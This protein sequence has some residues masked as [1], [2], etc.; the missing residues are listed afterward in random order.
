MKIGHYDSELGSK[1]GVTTYIRRIGSAQENAGHTVYYFSNRPCTEA[2]VANNA[3][4][5][6]SS[7]ED[8]Y[9]Q[10]KSLGLDILH[11][12]KGVG[13]LPP[14]DLAV[15]RTLHGHQPYCPSGSKFLKRWNQPC[16]RPYSL[17]GCLWGHLVDHCGSMRPQNLHENFQYT[18]AERNTLRGI[19]VITVSQF[20]KQQ[21]V[22]IGY[23]ADSID[24][25]YNF[26]PEQTSDSSPPNTGIPHFVFL[27]RITPSKG[28]DWLLRALQ[29]VQPPVH[30]DIAGE[31]YKADEM[32]QLAQRR[33]LSD[34]VTFHGWLNPEQVNNL[35]CSSRA[36]VFPSIWHEPA[37]LVALEAMTNARAVIA[38]RTGGIPEM[39]VDEC[40]GL[41]VEPNRVSELAASIE[42]LATDW[43]LAKQLGE[44]G[45]KMAAE[46]F[47]LQTHFHQLMQLYQQAIQGCQAN[48]ARL[49]ARGA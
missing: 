21:M 39:V 31:G 1:G 4:V 36:L 44:T 33:G 28:L 20:L 41:L 6:V 32:R 11:L 30:L 38:S 16:D 8:M 40:N 23:L 42:R 34:R 22:Q 14:N 45:R 2:M 25:L 46:Q 18:Q 13:Q 7:N 47:T 3:P 12:H 17:S 29:Q 10:A 48:S 19:P 35:I 43:S 24:V 26:A 5:L 37:G 49:L 9:S 15:I 27:G